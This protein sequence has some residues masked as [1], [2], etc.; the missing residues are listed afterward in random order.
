MKRMKQMSKLVVMSIMVVMVLMIAGCGSS[1]SD[2]F[3]GKWIT[4]NPKTNVT[5]LDIQPE[6]DK[7]VV[8]KET[9]Y[10]YQDKITKKSMKP[11]TNEDHLEYLNTLTKVENNINAIVN[12]KELVTQDGT[13]T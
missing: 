8:I 6:K 10:G 5:I 13:Y 11:F 12:K 1:E 9:V 4:K 3:T 7:K 2:N